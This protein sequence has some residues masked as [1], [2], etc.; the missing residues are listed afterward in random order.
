MIL[1]KTIAGFLLFTICSMFTSPLASSVCA[2]EE[3]ESL[4]SFLKSTDKIEA[5]YTYP[6]MVLAAAGNGKSV[7]AA[8]TPIMI[9]CEEEITTR[10]LVSGSNVNFSVVGDIKDS[11][12]NIL[13]KSGTPVTATISFSKSKG[14]IGKSGEL[15]VTDFHT[16]A[17]DR[18]YVPL[19]GS[20]SARPDD[21]MTLSIVL[22]VLIC[23]L[24]LL[25]KGEEAQ[26]PVGATKTAYTITYLYNKPEI[27][28]F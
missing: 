14:M 7:L 4:Y 26:L 19:S 6:S 25:M 8:H 16:T 21:K 2:N 15:T 12:G 1:K 11:N 28:Y 22:S 9:R 23:P 17:I 20:V 24:F 18:T 10:D 27:L 3:Q 5:S 13:I